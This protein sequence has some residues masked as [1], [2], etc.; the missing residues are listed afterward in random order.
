M[1]LKI[2][3]LI[4]S[5]GAL[6]FLLI[7]LG[8]IRKSISFKKHGVSTQSTV[9]SVSHRGKGLPEV[10]V[11]FKTQDGNEVTASALKRQVVSKGDNVMTWYDPES[12]KKIDFGDTIGYNMRGVAAAS[13]IFL[14]GFYYFVRY[15]LTDRKNKNLITSGMKIAAEFVSVEKNEKYRMGDNNPWVIKCKWIDRSNNHEYFFV[16]KDYT[17]DPV[18]YLNGRTHVDIFVDPANPCKYYMDTTF[19]PIGNNTIG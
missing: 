16:S 15:S 9:I 10:T 3:S 11:I 17:I 5:I 7:P 2:V 13:I 14:F 1:K 4:V 12:P 6:A 19:M 8:S 18:P